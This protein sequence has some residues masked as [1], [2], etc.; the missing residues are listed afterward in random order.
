MID[1]PRYW[2]YYLSGLALGIFAAI[3]LWNSNPLVFPIG[4]ILF[5]VSFYF[6]FA[7]LKLEKENANSNTLNTKYNDMKSRVVNTEGGAYTESNYGDYIT[8]QDHRI[9]VNQDVSQLT[10]DI[11][12]I[13]DLLQ[14]QGYSQNAVVHQIVDELR[15]QTISNPKAKRGILRWKNTL[16]RSGNS[17]SPALDMMIR[18]A[19][20]T[21]ESTPN[22][23]YDLTQSAIG[24]YQQLE[25]L[26]KMGAWKDADETTLAIVENLMPEQ[27]Y[28]DIDVDEIPSSDLKK[29]NHLWR[30]YSNG[31]FGLSVQ[32]SIW[33]EISSMH[34]DRWEWMYEEAYL[35]FIDYV[36]W[37]RDDDRIYYVNIHYSLNAP[38]G[39][40]PAI[41]YFSESHNARY[42]GKSNYCHLDQSRFDEFMSRE[43]AASFN[44]PSWLKRWLFKE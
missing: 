34:E 19:E 32:Q 9:H 20:L 39:H 31:K 4:I 43:Y 10:A 1:F 33:Q 40:L 3:L 2:L 12:N 28:S 41:L 26:L 7:G 11:Q 35:A 14:S 44:L 27:D 24:N 17:T 29:I 37:A 21:T 36:G 6:C 15:P 16:K 42:Y 18:I 13:L 23:S 25:E 30:K 38:K 5:G 22:S 8:I